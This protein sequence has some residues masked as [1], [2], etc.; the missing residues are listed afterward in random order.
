VSKTGDGTMRKS[1]QEIE[2]TAISGIALIIG[3]F[4]ESFAARIVNSR[5]GALD[6]IEIDWADLHEQTEKVFQQMISEL[7]DAI[8]ERD[9]IAKK[10]LSGARKESN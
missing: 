7:T 2:Q 5:V 4:S 10:K 8:D 3:E 6:A 1:V 9:M